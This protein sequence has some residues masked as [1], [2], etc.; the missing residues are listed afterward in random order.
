MLS[1]N[2]FSYSASVERLASLTTI[3]SEQAVMAAASYKA[4]GDGV[5]STLDDC[6]ASK[7]LRLGSFID[8]DCVSSVSRTFQP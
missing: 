2:E 5:G 6:Q 7:F 1:S 4:P 8:L 3:R